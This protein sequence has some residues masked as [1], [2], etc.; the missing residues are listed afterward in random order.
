MQSFLPNYLSFTKKIIVK[1]RNKENHKEKLKI[2]SNY[3]KEWRQ[4]A[5]ACLEDKDANADAEIERRQTSPIVKESPDL[6]LCTNERTSP[7][8]QGP[9]KWEGS[10]L[11]YQSKH[12]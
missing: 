9:V 11:C 10:A 12:S 2:K 6:F 7:A 3:T 4:T 8:Y 1:V 5:H